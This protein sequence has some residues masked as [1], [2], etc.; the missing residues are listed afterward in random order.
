MGTVETFGQRAARQLAALMKRHH[1]K[2]GAEFEKMMADKG[3]EPLISQVTIRRILKD[4]LRTGPDA[5]TLRRLAEFLGEAYA[6]AFPESEEERS[7]EANYGG[8]KIA[9]HS[10]GAPLSPSS[11]EQIRQAIEQG[12][13]HAHKVHSLKGKQKR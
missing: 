10:K 13:E 6:A 5:K 1:I 2:T 3:F 7:Y 12:V 4:E 9:F 11:V 8:T